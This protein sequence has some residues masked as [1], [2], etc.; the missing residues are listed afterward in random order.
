MWGA[1]LLTSGAAAFGRLLVVSILPTSVLVVF[2]WLSIRADAYNVTTPVKPLSLADVASVGT[3]VNTPAALLLLLT[4]AVLAAVIQTFQ[5]GF[6]RVLE[7]YW[8]HTSLGLAASRL[9]VRLQGRRVGRLE[10]MISAAPTEETLRRMGDPK[11]LCQLSLE[12]QQ[13]ELRDVVRRNMAGIYANEQRNLYPPDRNDI[14]GTRLGNAIRSFERRAGERYGYSTI[15]VW[16]RLYP[17]LSDKLSAAYHSSVDALDAAVN[18]CL[19]FAVVAVLS[20][21]AFFNDPALR[22]VPL[23]F[24]VLAA[25][26]YRSAISAAAAQG[27]YEF[28]AFD[29]HRFEM[30]TSL[31]Q[32][33]PPGT[34]AEAPIAGRISD[35]FAYGVG[36]GGAELFLGDVQYVHGAS[37][38]DEPPARVVR[39]WL[40]RKKSTVE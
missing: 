39:W 8:G 13:R 26:S 34:R 7:G 5:I 17:H 35:F 14:L 24:I 11:E 6:V 33:L 2:V 12:R 32:E 28:V 40:W 10:Q 4:I 19:V 20:T 25:L 23:P 36:P 18:F 3:Q 31:H 30:L 37:K 27:L 9:G 21:A 38:E 16:P 15:P 1:T 22:W 29:L